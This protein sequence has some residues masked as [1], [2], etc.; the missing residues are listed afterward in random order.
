MPINQPTQVIQRPWNNVNVSGAIL[1]PFAQGIG[2]GLG[3]AASSGLKDLLGIQSP[4]E[5]YY[6]AEADAKD[7]K[8][9]V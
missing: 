8:S 2:T 6:R 9:V 4:Q 1:T 7:R 3:E 5:A